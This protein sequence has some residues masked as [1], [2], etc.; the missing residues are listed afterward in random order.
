MSLLRRVATSPRVWLGGVWHD[1]R[2]AARVFAKNPGF[3]A[4]AVLS[5]AFGSGANVA[6]FSAAGA[7]LLRRLTLAHPHALLTV[8]SQIPFGLVVRNLASHPDYLDIRA[9][10]G[11]FRGLLA[12]TTAIVAYTPAPGARA[13]SKV[14][15][16]VSANFF[17]V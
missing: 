2:H 14:A 9:R 8:G 13:Q 6:M 12:F 10:T 11:T 1:V 3:R 4:I 7:L 5:M 16:L 15:T 17:Q